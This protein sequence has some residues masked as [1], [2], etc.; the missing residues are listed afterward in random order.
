MVDFIL[1]GLNQTVEVTTDFVEEQ[2]AAETAIDAP[3]L[4][5]TMTA[6]SFNT[7]FAFGEN[8]Y[9]TY[10]GELP[11]L[12]HTGD[13]STLATKNLTSGTG[14]AALQEPEETDQTIADDTI[15]HFVFEI[16]GARNQTG[17]YSNVATINTEIDDL[18]IKTDGVT[19]ASAT[20]LPLKLQHTIG[21]ADNKTDTLTTT[22][23]LV[24]QLKLN[25]GS[26]RLIGAS[27]GDIY[28]SSNILS[29]LVG[30]LDAL[31][32]GLTDGTYTHG[33]NSVTITLATTGGNAVTSAAS[34]IS[35][36]VR[37]GRVAGVK[38]T[39]AGEG[40]QAGQ[41]LTFT[42]NIADTGSAATAMTGYTVVA[43]DL[44]N[45]GGFTNN[46]YNFLFKASD[47]LSFQVGVNPKSGSSF[48]NQTTKN[49]KIKINMS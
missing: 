45:S 9:H 11:A 38:F 18:L 23:N 15:R 27:N 12:V 42:T 19:G 1:N 46:L 13:S 33:T 24:R 17:L 39:T 31:A 20:Q 37:G 28:H 7:L 4:D 16:T 36:I 5:L 26:S 49:Y 35:M 22:A 2:A 48:A 29:N 47:T 21:E 43:G 25:V 10:P 6:T 14:N 40:Y 8:I 44:D 41:T 34:G 32:T 30:E 3:V